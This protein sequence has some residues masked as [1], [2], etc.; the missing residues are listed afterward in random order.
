MRVKDV[1]TGQVDLLVLSVLEDGPAHGYALVE[2][3]RA[4]ST[5]V[6]HLAE[7]TI[8]PALYRLERRRFVTSEWQT[9]AGRRRRLYSLTTRGRTELE[10]RR[11][12]WRRFSSAVEAVL[13]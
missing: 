4:R 5:G 11:V 7:G 13:A 12:E 2:A 6:F 9:V 1:L 8:Y 10:Q 3:I